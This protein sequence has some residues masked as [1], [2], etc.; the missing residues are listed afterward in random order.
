MNGRVA[1]RLR[2]AVTGLG[3]DDTKYVHDK[4]DHRIIRLHPLC[5]R[6]LY[7]KL[8]QAHKEA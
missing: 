8:K 5:A 6:A 1:K 4:F 3:H 2:R 7:K